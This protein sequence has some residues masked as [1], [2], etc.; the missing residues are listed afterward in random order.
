MSDLQERVTLA[1][2]AINTPERGR[3]IDAAIHGALTRDDL[4]RSDRTKLQTALENLRSKAE[5]S[6][7]RPTGLASLI[8][9]AMRSTELSDTRLQFA[10]C[11]LLQAAGDTIAQCRTV[12]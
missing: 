8:R 10:F 3:I 6:I 7:A 11:G 1:A 12:G 2:A 5:S 9:Q 4:T